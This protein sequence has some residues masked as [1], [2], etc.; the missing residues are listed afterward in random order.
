MSDRLVSTLIVSRA[1][2]VLYVCQNHHIL[3]FDRLDI[4]TNGV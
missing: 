4:A 1:E 3:G 2:L